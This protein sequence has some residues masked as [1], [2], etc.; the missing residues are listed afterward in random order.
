MNF[1]IKM[2]LT[3]RLAYRGYNTKKNVRATRNLSFTDGWRNTLASV[4]VQD[5]KILTFT[6]TLLREDIKIEIYF[7]SV[8]Y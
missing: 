2:K 8:S 6:V 1:V 3:L 7:Y 4:R 5:E